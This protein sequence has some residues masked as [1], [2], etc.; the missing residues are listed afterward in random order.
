MGSSNNPVEDVILNFACPAAGVILAN[1]VF[2]APV[3]SL[4]KAL[5][6]CEL[7]DL[8]PM[9][10]AFMTG[11]CVGWVTYSFLIQ[12]YFVFL[13]NAPGIIISIWLNFGAIKLQYLQCY[14]SSCSSMRGIEI[15]R[16]NNNNLSP[17]AKDNTGVDRKSSDEEIGEIALI[18]NRM[19][20]LTQHERLTLSVIIFWIIVL[21]SISFIPSLSHDSK[22]SIIGI[23]NNLNLIIFFGAPLSTIKTVIYTKNSSSIHRWLMITSTLNAAFWGIYGLVLLDPY[24]VIPNVLGFIFG[25]IQMLLTCCYPRRSNTVMDQ[26][27]I[28]RSYYDSTQVTGENSSLT[29]S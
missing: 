11:N 15:T 4:Q 1:A 26:A 12:D 6:E 16:S 29:S 10:W 18:Q 17:K 23:I 13:A 21:T 3:K 14:E 19:Q 2:S 24:I 20:S 22:V 25:L 7:G 9:P 5:K 27:V 28:H 8:N